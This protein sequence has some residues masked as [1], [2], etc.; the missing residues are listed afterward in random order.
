MDQNKLF[1]ASL[2]MMAMGPGYTYKSV[3]IR[4]TVDYYILNLTA[5]SP[6]MTCTVE[7]HELNMSDH[8]PI[9]VVLQSSPF[10]QKEHCIT[11]SQVN[12]HKAAKDGSLW[13][14]KQ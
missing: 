2:G 5:G 6:M 9:H 3:E 14:M 4:S 1:V 12:W 11:N 7:G 13:H 10:V 8:L